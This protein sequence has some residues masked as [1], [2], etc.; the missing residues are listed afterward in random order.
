[1]VR[2]IFWASL[3]G[4]TIW[5]VLDF[6]KRL[7]EYTCDA[8]NDNVVV[9]NGDT[10]WRIVTTNCTGNIR[11][12]VDDHVEFYGTDIQVGQAIQLKQNQ[13]CELR[14]TDGGQAVA[15]C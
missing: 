15:D 12:A 7:D 10:V 9:N 8:T 11:K 14:R 1:M 5:M 6:N 2:T 4:G 13:D 3:V